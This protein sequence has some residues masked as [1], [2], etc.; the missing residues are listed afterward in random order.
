VLLVDD[1]VELREV[2][3]QALLLRGGFDVVGEASDG[4]GAVAA[5]ATVHP[6]VIVLDLGLPDFA[7]RE[8]VSRVRAAAPEAKIVI[9]TGT[10][11]VERAGLED[12]VSAFVR[13]DEDLHY[14]V[15]LLSDLGRTGHRSA[16]LQVGVD[17]SNVEGARRFVADRCVEWGCE[18]VIPDA[19]LVVSELVANALVHV[20]AGCELQVGFARGLLRIDVTDRG[21]GAPNPQRASTTA[22]HGRG[23]FLVSATC[24]AWGVE[25][26]PNGG[27]TVWAEIVVPDDVGRGPRPGDPP[28]PAGETPHPDVVDVSDAARSPVSTGDDVGPHDSASARRHSELR[29]KRAVATRRL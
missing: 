25:A 29:P 20:G 28:A 12:R 16:S 8:L 24:A 9:Y 3:R 11:T 1:V 17:L 14:L 18:G 5:A 21:L 22:E 10:Y 19:E 26:D 27:K 6:D 15:D 7:G 13:K 4:A 2:V 23:L